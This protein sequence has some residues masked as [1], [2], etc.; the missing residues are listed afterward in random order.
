M[1]KK[2]TIKQFELG[3]AHT[4]QCSAGERRDADVNRKHKN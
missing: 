1:K 4:I 3:S 2:H